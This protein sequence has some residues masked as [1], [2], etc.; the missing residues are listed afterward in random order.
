[1]NLISKTDTTEPQKKIP[2]LVEI[3]QQ[4]ES[5]P[6]D[7]NEV[8]EWWDEKKY[9]KGGNMVLGPTFSQ[10]L[11]IYARDNI[12]IPWLDVLDG[13]YFIY[14]PIIVR[15]CKKFLN[16]KVDY[17]KQD[18]IIENVIQNVFAKFSKKD[19]RRKKNGELRET[20]IGALIISARNECFT[21]LDKINIKIKIERPLFE[22]V[23]YDERIDNSNYNKR[24]E[25]LT[26][27]ILSE[28]NDKR[29]YC[30]YRRYIMKSK[31]KQIALIADISEEGVR[32]HLIKFRKK[33]EKKIRS[34]LSEDI[35]DLL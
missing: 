35:E 5:L 3:Q 34:I 15:C 28:R 29:R 7:E 33:N 11:W 1:M 14:I 25:A 19:R 21:I 30:C 27:L 31:Y 8:K 16:S 10:A 17:S 2:S 24:I 26:K 4:Q 32:Q 12:N 13:I 22:D 6:I 9:K 18:E 20:I 23:T